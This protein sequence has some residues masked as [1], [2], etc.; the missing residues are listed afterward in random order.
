MRTSDVTNPGFR[1]QT[2]L[3]QRLNYTESKS[4]ERK[5]TPK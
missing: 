1:G 2:E 3:D 4:I 5:N